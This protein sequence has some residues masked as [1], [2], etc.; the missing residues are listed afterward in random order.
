MT[1]G[2]KIR[3]YREQQGMSQKT[4]AEHLEFAR[5]TYAQYERDEREPSLKRAIAI[6]R[7]FN[8]SLDYLCNNSERLLVD[9]TDIDKEDQALI[10]NIL[11]KYNKY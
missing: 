10:F 4:V 5:A 9:I 6:S 7:F 3:K 2:E 8:I 1:F 11:R